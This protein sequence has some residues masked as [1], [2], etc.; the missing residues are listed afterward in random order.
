[1]PKARVNMATHGKPRRL[2]QHPQPE[3][4]ILEDAFDGL[5]AGR[6]MALDLVAL[7]STELDAG[8]ALRL[9]ARNASAFEVIGAELDVGA[10]LVVHFAIETRAVKHGGCGGSDGTQ[11]FHRP[12][13]SP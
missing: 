2:A 6:L 1:M 13:G 4:D 11:Q 9:P 12:S 7:I 8:A 3:A 10:E 5:P